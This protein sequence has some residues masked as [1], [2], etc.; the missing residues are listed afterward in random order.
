[1]RRSL[2]VA[3][4]VAAALIALLFIRVQP[5]DKARVV[6]RGS[7]IAVASGRIAFVVPGGQPCMAPRRGDQLFFR[8][9]QHAGDLDLNVNFAYDPPRT[10]P[11]TWPAGDWCSSLAKFVEEHVHP[12]DL[13]DPG[14]AESRVSVDLQ[15]ALAG[16]QLRT[17][18]V[19]AR[20][21]LPPGWERTRPVPDVA[22]LVTQ[23]PPVL[24]IGLDGADWELLDDFIARGAMPNLARLVR[25]GTSGVLET[26]HP[27]LSP[28][29]WTTMMTGVSPL[30]HQIL[31]FTHFN[32]ST[33]QKEPIT[34]DERAVPAVWN[35]ATMAGKRVA[36]FGL[37]ATYPAEPV[38]GLMVS[39]RTFTFL[40]AE[41]TP[42][43]GIVYPPSREAWARANVD[44]AETSIDY[45][46][47]HRF[48]PWLTEAES[49][50]LARE[51]NPYSKPGSALRRILIETEIY[52][53][54]ANDVLSSSMPDLSIVYIQGTDTIGHV[55]A[56]FAPPKQPEVTQEDYDRYHQVP[57]LYFRHIDE[58]LGGFIKAAETH[59]AIVMLASDH[60]FRWKEGRPVTLSSVATAT[61]AKWHRN[62]GIF[63]LWG[64]GIAAS[65][66][67]KVHGGIRQVCSTLLDVSGLPRARGVAQ[68]LLS[69]PEQTRVSV[70]HELDYRHWFSRFVPPAP[71]AATAV[72][73]NEELA[74]LKALG[75]IGTGESTGPR[76]AGITS[77]KTAGAYNNAGLILKHEN[78]IAESIASF[79]EALTIDPNLASAAWNLSD[80]LFSRNENLAEADDLLLRALQNGLP[81]AP[82]YAIERAIKYQRSGHADRS[83]KLMEGAVARKGDDAE[84]RM[85]RGRYRVDQKDCAGALE[86]FLAVEQLQPNDAVAWAS[87]GLAQICLGNRAEAEASFRR[88]LEINPNQPVLRKFLQQ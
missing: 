11:A 43:P 59:H 1:M 55:F 73:A 52:R 50:D 19:S 47:M 83:L 67:H 76:P 13:D 40:F 77:T 84:L 44:A 7:T 68:T 16:A 29:L 79:H 71:S 51:P 65:S 69:V 54:I 15:R 12:G 6:R 74:K 34:S 4:I 24:F 87:A 21:Q 86:D 82:K 63:L 18:S 33:G 8:R 37:W 70:P 85:F 5:P 39:D 10:L 31:D 2:V 48:L 23:S 58:L 62:E 42:P 61:A 3:A 36:V 80:L 75:Y 49:G 25:E 88:S 53:R 22:K 27:P 46:T 26:E 81:E 35:M 57:E 20:L 14:A 28:L 64:Q 30:E 78:R 45:A 38:H 41:S 17:S 72:S 32:P 60:G 9:T 56:P 66:G